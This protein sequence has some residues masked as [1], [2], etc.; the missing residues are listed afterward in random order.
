MV[1]VGQYTNLPID[2]QWSHPGTTEY[3]RSLPTP[4]A[5]TQRFSTQVL[6][7]FL[8]VRGNNA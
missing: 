8:T 3:C 6:A 2:G 4:S 1:S 5:V 7:H